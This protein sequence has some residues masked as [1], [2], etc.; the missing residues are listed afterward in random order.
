MQHAL[1]FVVDPVRRLLLHRDVS[2]QHYKP[3][4]IT[5]YFWV[6]G[7]P[8]ETSEFMQL[9]RD[10]FRDWRLQVRGLVDVERD[11]E[12]EDL[13]RL[14]KQTQLTKHNCIQGWSGVAEWGG[15]P[16]ATILDL[17]VPK[18]EA[19][20]LVFT[21]YQ[22]GRQSYPEGPEYSQDR[23]FYEVIDMELA[24]HPQT[25]LAYE[26]NGRPLPLEHGAPL[27]LR[28]ET[29]LGYKMVKY[30]RS[31]ELVADYSTIGDGQGGFREDIQFYGRGAEV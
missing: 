27:R 21:S 7:R 10:N 4:D 26:M 5:T 2:K 8:P 24:R 22:H 19:R 17:C 3:S 1:G 14:P 23:P 20:Y 15:V 13:K 16:V 28:V 29:L 12:M 6:N 30:L 31:I 11:F 25:L 9:V 18:P